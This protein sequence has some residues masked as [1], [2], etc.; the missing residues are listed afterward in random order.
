MTRILRQGDPH[1]ALRGELA[2]EMGARPD[3]ERMAAALDLARSL[4]AAEFLA[5]RARGRAR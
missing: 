2:A 4:L 5:A 1:M 3:R